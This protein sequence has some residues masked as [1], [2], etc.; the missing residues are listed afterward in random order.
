MERILRGV[1]RYRHT[2]REQ[3]VQEFRKVR[4]NPQ[5]KAVFFTCMDSR[6]IP[7]RFTETHVGDM[8]VVR[9]AGNLVPHAEHFQDEYFSCEPAAL[10]LGCVVNN[11]KHIIVCGHSDCKAM[12][13]LYQLKDPEFSSLKNRRISPL[14]AW[15]CEHANTSLA[16][17][18]N[19]KEI[20][21][22]K[23]LI[24]SSETP[25]RKFV[26]YIDPENN[27]AIED[28]LSQV[29]TLQQIENVASY[30]FLK[31]RL[32]SHDLHIHAL[33]FDIYTGDIYFFSRNSKRFI[34]IDES[35]IERLLDEVRRYYS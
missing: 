13:L 32:E 35:S 34:A 24:F 4:D 7:T 9:N 12:N 5:P 29:N 18:Q 14:R 30:G 25:L 21:L 15:L 27:F 22:D 31:R 11:I 19:L 20:G 1:M 10:E 8:F 28:K 6:M 33:W 26:A 16:K 2:T 3:M 17:F 23:P